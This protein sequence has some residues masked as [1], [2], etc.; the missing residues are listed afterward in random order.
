MSEPLLIQNGTI[1]T[2]E[3]ENR[4]L[5]K[6][7]LLC[8]NGRITRI[9]PAGEFPDFDGM[10]LDARNQLVMP[11]FINVHMHFYSTLVRG[12]G[13]A[14]PSRNFQEVLE[15]L[16]WRLDRQLQL[17]DVYYSALIALLA[18]IR[19]GT[20]T[21]I[22][23]HA[24]PGAAAGSLDQ[25]A[26]AVR[27]TGL[28]A[29][30]CYELSD[31]DGPE[32]AAAGLAENIRFIRQCQAERGNQLK[33][34]FGLHAAFTLSEATLERAV[35]EAAATG[36]GF[37]F[38]AAE[39]ESDQE[40]N[41]REH[42]WRVIERFHRAGV[43]GPS[44]LAAHCVHVDGREMDLL[45]ATGTAVAHNPQSNLN[46]AVG[47]ADLPALWQRGILTGLGTDA[48]TVDMREEVRA[49]LWAQH[50]RQRNPG[51][52]FPECV[53]TLIRGSRQIAARYWDCGLGELKEG[54]AADIILLDYIPPTP[55][56]PETFA[57]HLIFGLQLAPVDTTIAGGK[58]LM[59]HKKLC[60]DLDEEE[61]GRKSRELA[62]KLWERF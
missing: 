19:H 21:L 39:A 28:R 58:I 24:S 60:L 36:T 37:H 25:I 48:M 11:G 14:L 5:E 32:A 38:H 47:I 16:W 59:R 3:E 15:H 42:G 10:V 6:H 49:A 52:S 9:A 57:G 33:A 2:L 13:K 40:Y 18:C 8:E 30:L 62:A 41:L 46:N 23:H 44:S 22:D 51:V 26:R 43:L 56:T 54:N 12:L 17:E 7:A 29:C 20:T 31:R 35:A 45:A 27:Q 55:L 61:A 4:V 50:H 1:V 34:L 53:Q